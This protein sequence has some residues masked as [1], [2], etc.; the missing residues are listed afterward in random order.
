MKG[1]MAK[2]KKFRL[3][4]F[5]LVFLPLFG[6]C[7]G[8]Q[9]S[10]KY[11]AAS[12]LNSMESPI[13]TKWATDS[14]RIVSWYKHLSTR[15]TTRFS[16]IQIES[17]IDSIE[18][19]NLPEVQTRKLT[20]SLRVKKDRL[21]DELAN[22]R[23]QLQEK[24]AAKYKSLELNIQSKQKSDTVGRFLKNA[25]NGIASKVAGLNSQN[26]RPGSLALA[27]P[28]IGLNS[29]PTGAMPNPDLP[30]LLSS[31]DFAELNLSEDLLE[32]G[33]NIAVPT[34]EVLHKLGNGIPGTSEIAGIKS[35]IKDPSSAAET[36]ASQLGNI[37]G[38]GDQLAQAEQL[39]AQNEALKVADQMKD[40]EGMK[41]RA[42][43]HFQGK[44]ET[45][46]KSMEMLAKKKAKYATV[47]SLADI[48]KDDWMPRNGLKGR[49]FRD[50]FRLGVHTGFRIS[51]DTL[52]LDFYPNASYRI[53]GRVEA[54][55]GAIY[56]VRLN[57]KDFGTNQYRPVWGMAT[58]VVLKTF[59]S[60]FL[61]V[62]L[63]GNS[64]PGHTQTDNSNYRDWRWTTW[65]GVQT[66]FKLGKQWV[67][68]VQMMY[69]FDKTLKDAFPERLTLRFGVQYKLKS[70]PKL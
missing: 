21:F 28:D 66:N 51:N 56:Q 6:M 48:K 58:F 17:K 61:R 24:I 34:D 12:L 11:F 36:A 26:G 33:G 47:G 10:Q 32:L 45:L 20:D 22:K 63:D 29:L 23:D 37:Q 19:L 53:T 2:L 42:M 15:V 64:Y 49:P 38:A 35:A 30:G 40:M 4:L 54:G 65:A 9:P 7:Q 43:S 25:S 13:T 57:H 31:E 8:E 14:S 69:G 70:K 44:G 62:E 39:K 41:A 16:D 67:G 60:T 18:S 52:L 50:R 27:K 3:G 68:I 1:A 59:K 55:L 5:S 46:A